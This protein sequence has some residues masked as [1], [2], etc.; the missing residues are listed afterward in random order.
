MWL[1]VPEGASQNGGVIRSSGDVSGGSASRR[2]RVAAAWGSSLGRFQLDRGGCG[3][4]DDR[5]DSAPTPPSAERF[6]RESDRPRIDHTNAPGHGAGG[7]GAYLLAA[8]VPGRTA[9]A[10]SAGPAGAG[11]AAEIG[12]R[13]PRRST[14]PRGAGAVV[15]RDVSRPTC[16]SPAT[17]PTE[18]LRLTRF[19]SPRRSD[20]DGQCW[21]RQT[22]PARAVARARRRPSDVTRSAASCTRRCWPPAYRADVA[23]HAAASPGPRPRRRVGPRGGFDRVWRAR[24]ARRGRPLPVGRRPRRAR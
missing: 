5:I 6:Q 12:R 1:P 20:R 16:C 11:R 2:G 9:P 17:T 21:A 15:H 8:L 18:R 3:A 19:L 13:S 4:E 10:L 23:G 22:S 14:G 24:R 7:G